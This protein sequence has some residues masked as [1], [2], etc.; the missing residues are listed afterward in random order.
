MVGMA[1]LMWPAKARALS[2]GC[3]LPGYEAGQWKPPEGSD[4]VEWCLQQGCMPMDYDKFSHMACPS[5]WQDQ[6]KDLV[7]CRV[8]L[9]MC[10]EIWGSPDLDCEG[11]DGP[12]NSTWEDPWEWCWG[13]G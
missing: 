6:W 13:C 4:K 2:L 3:E 5:G 8:T 12:G 11:P 9:G 7:D 10:H 1:Y